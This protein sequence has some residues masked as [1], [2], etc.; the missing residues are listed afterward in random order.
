MNILVQKVY[1][2]SVFRINICVGREADRL[3]SGR[4]SA[5]V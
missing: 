4:S 3:E 1:L 5:A 2:G